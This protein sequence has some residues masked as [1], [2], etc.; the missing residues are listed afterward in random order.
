MYYKYKAHGTKECKDT[1]DERLG[2]FYYQPTGIWYT[3]VVN[4][5]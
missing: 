4:R 1:F 5:D 3:I 2:E